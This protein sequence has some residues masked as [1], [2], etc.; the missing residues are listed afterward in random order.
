MPK[1]TYSSLSEVGDLQ[2][3][4]MEFISLW[5]HTE[6]KATPLKEIVKHMESQG[7]HRPSTVYSLGILI[8]KG[9]I[10]RGFEISNK[11]TFVQLRTI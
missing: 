4:I 7:V 8:K 6:K 2:I 10:R 5:V 3:Q 9:Y 11:T 1:T